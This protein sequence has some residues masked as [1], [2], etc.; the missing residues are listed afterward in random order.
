MFTY[1]D[2]GGEGGGRGE[3]GGG[4][5]GGGEGPPTERACFVHTFIILNDEWQPFRMATLVDTARK[6]FFGHWPLPFSVYLSR[7]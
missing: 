2:G 6:N 3:G 1:V 4:R 7:H 5:G